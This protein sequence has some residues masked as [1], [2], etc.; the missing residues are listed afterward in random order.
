[1][2]E[3]FTSIPESGIQ[4]LL[5]QWNPDHR[6]C[7]PSLFPHRIHPNKHLQS[8]FLA[9]ETLCL[10]CDF[11]E[12]RVHN[13]WQRERLGAA[14]Q[15][16]S[17][18]CWLLHSDQWSPQGW[19]SWWGNTTWENWIRL[20]RNIC[21]WLWCVLVGFSVAACDKVEKRCPDTTCKAQR[22]LDGRSFKCV[23]N[24][25]LCNSNITW[26]PDTHEERHH[27]TSYYQGVMPHLWHVFWLCTW[28][29]IIRIYITVVLTWSLCK[30]LEKFP[31][32]PSVSLN[33]CGALIFESQRLASKLRL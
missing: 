4:S 26:S 11:Q 21:S 10:P 30:N 32:I 1:M 14:L 25:D 13:S 15:E 16:H 18:L 27:A 23:C 12:E 31:Q 22:I 7:S 28:P 24:T 2:N 19:C 8:V 29:V 5:W 6:S 17:V 33:G 3:N 20:K 9:A